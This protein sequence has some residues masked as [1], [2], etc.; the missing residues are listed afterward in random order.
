MANWQT[1]RMLLRMGRLHFLL[2]GLVLYCVGALYARASGA[3]VQLSQIVWGYVVLM[4]GHLSVSYSND[5]FDFDA[6]KQGAQTPF[7]GGS[8]TLQEHPDLRPWALRI[9]V[10]L[11]ALSLVAG[12]SFI[13]WYSFSPWYI[14]ALIMGNML[15]YF[16]SAP[17]LSLSYRGWGEVATM[18]AT[19]AIVPLTG[20]VC[21]NG[22]LTS[23]ILGFVPVALCY[24]AYFILTVELPDMDEDRASGKAT[25]VATF[26]QSPAL[27]T[28]LAFALLG[29]ALN[30]V[31]YSVGALLPNVNFLVVSLMTLLP[32]SAAAYGLRRG[33]GSKKEIVKT[34]QANMGSLV[35][36]LL[37]LD[38]Y[39]YAFV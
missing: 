23:S 39:L 19:G 6:D 11:I 8:G 16:Y 1:M 20:Y 13:L 28:I 29:T 14:P 12:T 7:S 10:A 15:G 30:A 21:A 5:Y 26:G 34:V 18:V 27:R 38:I 17:P 36:Y 25:Y 3:Q 37:L 9:A 32:L 31:L 4:F 2:C 24:G 22:K 33:P 35:L